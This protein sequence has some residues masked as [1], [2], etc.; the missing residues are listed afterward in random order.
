MLTRGP[1]RRDNRAPFAEKNLGKILPRDMVIPPRRI[2]MRHGDSL[3]SR[4]PLPNCVFEKRALQK[5]GTGWTARQR[6][7][8]SSSTGGG[9]YS[10]YVSSRAYRN[11]QPLMP[12][13]APKDDKRRLR[14]W[15]T[16]NNQ[17][18]KAAPH[19]LAMVSPEGAA[20]AVT[21]GP[22]VGKFHDL[23]IA[24]LR[25]GVAR[26]HAIALFFFSFW[27]EPYARWNRSKSRGIVS[28]RRPCGDDGARRD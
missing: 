5:A 14:K 25:Q 13:S 26:A 7:E 21:A 19:L 2:Q 20:T 9:T 3:G 22:A 11:L 16:K 17:G 4:P 28:L 6:T 24:E 27:V 18:S 15:R 8:E 12:G 10:Q 1:W 23:R